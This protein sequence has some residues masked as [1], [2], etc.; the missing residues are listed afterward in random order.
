MEKIFDNNLIKEAIKKHEENIL[1]ASIGMREDW[2]WTGE[3]IYEDGKLTQDLDNKI[4]TSGGINSSYWATPIIRIET[5]KG[6]FE[7]PVFIQD[8]QLLDVA[9]QQHKEKMDEALETLKNF[10]FEGETDG[11]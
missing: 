6:E 2:F 5:K 10:K 8:E 9:K 1:R 3:T 11:N 4:A 7:Y